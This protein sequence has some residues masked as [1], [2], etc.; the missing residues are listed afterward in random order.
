MENLDVPR[1]VHR[2]QGFSWILLKGPKLAQQQPTLKCTGILRK[3]NQPEDLQLKH[4]SEETKSYSCL[5]SLVYSITSVSARCDGIEIQ[6][7]TVPVNSLPDD[8]NSSDDSQSIYVETPHPHDI[9]SWDL[10]RSK[11]EDDLVDDEEDGERSPSWLENVREHVAKKGMAA[12]LG[13]GGLAVW[14][15]SQHT[16]SRAQ[17]VFCEYSPTDWVKNTS[18]RSLNIIKRSADISVRCFNIL[19]SLVWPGSAGGGDVRTL[20]TPNPQTR[21]IQIRDHKDKETPSDT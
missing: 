7:A 9:E 16:F 21:P 3:V 12:V 5:G 2:C 10:R 20:P 8:I 13:Q 17:D 1:D 15:G 6:V 11:V 14:E 19:G 4:L 18:I